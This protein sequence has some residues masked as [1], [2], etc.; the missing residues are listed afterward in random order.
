MSIIYLLSS[1]RGIFN[2]ILVQSSR[3][4]EDFSILWALQSICDNRVSGFV[5]FW[6][7][8]SRAICLR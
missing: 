3:S 5:H 8:R 6:A 4:W 1:I 7:L 2:V